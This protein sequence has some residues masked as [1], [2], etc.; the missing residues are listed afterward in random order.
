[1]HRISSF[2]P[3]IMMYIPWLIFSLT[4]LKSAVALYI[5]ITIYIIA[6]LQVLKMYRIASYA[7]LKI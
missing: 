1:M 3:L 2:A 4:F 6:S 7:L 5:N